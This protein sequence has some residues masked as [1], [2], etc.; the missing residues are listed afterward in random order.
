MRTNKF[1]Y[2]LGAMLCVSLASCDDFLEREP[3]DQISSAN[4]FTSA[5]D[6]AAY[7][8]CYYS[9]FPTHSGY[10]IG[11]LASDND[12][13]NQVSNSGSLTNYAPGQ[14]RVPD[15]SGSWN[16]TNIR[17]YNYFFENVLP[18]YESGEIT[19]D[20]L[21]V[22]QY[23]GEMYLLRAWDYFQKLQIF[24]DFPI[25]TR[26][27]SDNNEELIAAS[28]RS[29]RNKVARFILEDLDK[30]IDLMSNDVEKKNRLTKDV[31]LLLKSRVALF[32]ASFLTYHRGTPRVPGEVGW[33][34]ANMDYNADFSI[35]L[36]TEIDFFLS[37]CM[38][39]SKQVADKIVLTANSHQMNPTDFPTGW[40]PY[41]EMFS[42]IDM[43][44]IPEVLFWRSYNYD[45]NI[46]HSTGVYLYS[47]G[48]MGLTKGLIDSFL[49]KDGSPI[50]VGNNGYQGDNT[51][52]KVKE[53][54]DERLQ[55]FVAGE[56]DVKV[57]ADQN[58][59]RMNYNVVPAEFP[60]ILVPGENKD[61]TGYRFRK[62]FSYEPGQTAAVGLVS[63]YGSIVFRAVEAYLNYME[64]SYMKNGNL[65]DTAQKYW[66]AIRER[67]GVSSDFEKNIRLTDLNKEKVGDWGV[68]SGDR[69]VDATLYNI[70]R[71][72]RNELIGEGLRMM[73][74]KRWRALDQVKDYIVEGMNLW[75]GADG[76]Y[77]SAEGTS[78]LDASGT[79]TANV[80]APELGTYLQPF[81]KFE[82]NNL[83]Y[84]G[85]TWSKANYLYPIGYRDL[86]LASPD[87][88]V[89]NSVI[90]QNP[91]WPTEAGTALE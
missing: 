22:K 75:A 5:N 88:T 10:G 11:T 20:P 37:Q 77:V 15:Y 49:M 18:K 65:D 83:L 84:N 38:E 26:T 64:A 78:L 3:L 80:S 81:R 7:T 71:E 76:R 8:I 28:K 48:N 70:R 19:G 14:W 74:L 82:T 85:F 43:S 17:A 4:Y 1:H 59:P 67:A 35:D 25:I 60:N 46:L 68:Y 41:F 45:L 16:F 54:R 53:N 55:L 13:D 29:P 86:Q 36:D 9:N 32:E 12:T 40:N 21:M 2:I 57:L 79:T 52:M 56:E 33:P 89:E 58:H 66:R 73:D 39:S 62:C 30:A 87:G 90:Y 72:R 27:F 69:L 24:G 91:Y 63:T 44:V 50:Y 47:G 23:I 51:I 61:V 34:G 31:A 42:A 6:L